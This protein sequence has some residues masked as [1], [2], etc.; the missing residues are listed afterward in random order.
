MYACVCMCASLGV[1][2]HTCTCMCANLGV[3]CVHGRGKSN[4]GWY[5]CVSRKGKELTYVYSVV[6]QQ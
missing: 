2:M 4:G 3:V 6:V 5:S 1:Y